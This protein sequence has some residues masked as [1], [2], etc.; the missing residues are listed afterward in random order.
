MAPP[1]LTKQTHLI[2]YSPSHVNFVIPSLL[3]SHAAELAS[4]TRVLANNRLLP[5]EWA[6]LAGSLYSGGKYGLVK[7]EIAWSE[8]KQLQD[9]E[10]YL[11]INF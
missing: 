7:M 10:N 9:I 11:I 6:R 3:H 8:P 5:A 2:G 4:I 1:P